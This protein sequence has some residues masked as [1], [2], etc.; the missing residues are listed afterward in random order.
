MHIV[1]VETASVR[2]FDMIAEMADS[3]IEV[4]FVTE[5]LDAHRKNPGFELSARAARIVEVPH[6]ARG[7]L[8]D[9]L[10]GRLGPLAPDGVICRDEVHLPAA[11]ALARDLGLPHE[12][13][14]AARIL[15][16]KAAVRARLTERG[17]G[18]L[19]W[20]VA[21]TASQGLAAVDEIGLPVVVK[22]TAGGWS[23]GVSIA[24]SRAQAAHA[25][26]EVLGVPAGPDGTP[27]RALI[28]EYAVGRHVS[29]ELL[30]Q[31][32]RTVLLGFAERL[33]APPG[34][35][36]ELGGHFPARIEQEAAARAF[37]LDA[38][39]AIGV[40]SSAVHAELLLTPTGPELIE[41][42]GRV[43][44]HVVARQ[45]SLA[46]KRS[47][48][49]DLVALAVGDPV[50][51]AAPKET[52]VALHHLFSPVDAVV[53]G[54]K[55]QDVLT[56]EVI[57]S[58]VTA[59]TG[60]RVAALRTNHDRIGYVLARGRTGDEA[61]RHAAQAARRILKS[62]ELHP[63]P[64]TTRTA[65]ALPAGPKPQ[66]SRPDRLPVP[67]E[68]PTGCLL[69]PGESPTGRLLVPGDSRTHHL[70]VPGE[71]RPDHLPAAGESPTGCLLVPG[72]S[73]TGRLLVPGDSRT[74]HLP[75]PGESR[76]DH[77]PA[78][79]ESPTGCLPVPGESPTGRPPIPENSPTGRPPAA[80]DLRTGRPPRQA[81]EPSGHTPHDAPHDV[82][83]D[84]PHDVPCGEHVLVLLGAEDPADRIMAALGAVTARVSVI[85][86]SGPDGERR[87]RTRWQHQCR[88]QW[89]TA[90]TGPDI[91]AAAR[92]IHAAEPVRAML[93]F[94]AA[95]AARQL[96]DGAP[97]ARPP[98]AAT[99]GHTVVVAA[100]RGEVRALAVIDEEPGTRL[101][102]SGL[103]GPSR[104]ELTDRAVHAVR[105]AH[106]EGVVRC[107]LTRDTAR[108]GPGRPEPVLLPGLDA[109]TID[110]YDAVHTR[111][112][113]TAV[114]ESA[115]GRA[116][117]ARSRPAVALQRAVTTPGGRFR[118][119]EATTEEQ[120]Q[121]F[122]G[123]FRAQVFT[124][125]GHVHQDPR[126]TVWLRHT[127][128]AAGREQARRT[129]RKLEHSLV[130]RTTAQERTHVLLLDRIGAA[131]WTLDDKTPVLPADRF[132]L[133]V[134]SSTPGP[135]PAD[136]AA[137]TDLSDDLMLGHLARTL[138]AGHPVH[139]VAALSERLLQPAARLRALLGTA[140]EGPHEVARWVDKA[141]MKRIA[142]SHRIRCADG[143]LA[144]TAQDITEMFDRHGKIVLKPR[145][146]SGSRGVTVLA[147][148]PGLQAWLDTQFTPGTHLCEEFVD[149]PLCHI[150]AA[151]HDGEPVWDVSLYERD[152]MALRHGLPLSSATVADPALRTA[153]AHLLNQVLHAWQMDSGVL[154]LEAFVTGEH[155]T[156]CEV[157]ARPGGA[158]V[159]QAFR[160][161]TGIDLD[162]AKLLADAGLDP[163][164][165]RRDPVAAHAGWTVH[166]SGGGKLLEYD[167]SAVAP[168][169]Y[170]RS[171][172]ARVGDT[173][174]ASQFSGTGIST[175][176]F[177]HDSHTEVS[178]LLHRAEHDIHIVCAPAPAAPGRP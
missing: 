38:V 129:A 144:H 177:A 91:R 8:A 92:R 178:R 48:T 154:H 155:L 93:T 43:A 172:N 114:A 158:G 87:A 173:L 104:D 100:Y 69:V 24:W 21:A 2:G 25:L 28:E 86:T 128:V 116:P 75:V 89:H 22:P 83:H 45:M 136:L 65:D 41:I 140:G 17:I 133:S 161:T 63:V 47:L 42:N 113:V 23:V 102:P 37:V 84:A 56:D 70:P 15:S 39:R 138:D 31:D 50:R 120:L 176:V 96:R 62:L 139:R 97:A 64:G 18:S 16:D 152:T 29:A 14:S 147:S 167:D 164:H 98:A 59:G 132:R 165:R 137:R 49:A 10:R 121:T 81:G 105:A 107:V 13:L 157:A 149:A 26:A 168:H 74:H 27:P 57:E 145:A 169:A 160:A 61:A 72:E 112:L 66:N 76:P 118:V 141:V 125:A 175:H 146:A 111:G 127:V 60:D 7:V 134:L 119:L 34:Q 71:S 11:A 130:W 106:I 35:T 55:P 153:A 115:L 123:L 156:F 174:P 135:H 73:P 85:W 1:L 44:G 6:L 19:A 51:E 36:A 9:R 82:P 166:Y 4:S 30:V 52:V 126:P 88:G 122:P 142:R 5:T 108:P 77:L 12:S 53:R 171:V 54:A 79:G 124:R 148:W 40:R 94:S 20:R 67:R 99:P 143:L 163:R 110:L 33:P 131:T 103:D 80:G 109:A 58:H 162:H 46:L 170:F 117:R 150:D 3:G 159:A 101:C 151:V 32:Q 78:A 68:S 95:P 90:S